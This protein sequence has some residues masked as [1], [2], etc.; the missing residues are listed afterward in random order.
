LSEEQR[1]K[2]ISWEEHAYCRHVGG[3]KCREKLSQW[4]HFDSTAC[5]SGGINTGNI[6][7]N[8][9][10]SEYLLNHHRKFKEKSLI[11]TFFAGKKEVRR[12][13]AAE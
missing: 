8:R 4:R 3:K 9:D 13:G 7:S 12:R 2:T 6:Y 10:D 1:F 5:P 11:V